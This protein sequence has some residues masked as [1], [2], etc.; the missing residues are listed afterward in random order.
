M[1]IKKLI[2]ITYVWF[3]TIFRWPNL[4]DFWPNLASFT[5]HIGLEVR[6]FAIGAGGRE[7]DP[8]PSQTKYSKKWNLWLPALHSALWDEIGKYS[9]AD[10]YPAQRG[11][12][13]LRPLHITETRVKHWHLCPAYIPFGMLGMLFEQ[14]SL[15]FLHNCNKTNRWLVVYFKDL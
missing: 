12:A 11:V 10:W 1:F 2:F 8:R 15:L 5:V 14:G 13:L 7:F 3:V 4:V 6:V 9:A